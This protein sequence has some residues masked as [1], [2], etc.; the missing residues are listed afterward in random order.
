MYC[1]VWAGLFHVVSLVTNGCFYGKLAGDIY[2]PERKAKKQA[3]DKADEP[4]R[5]NPEKTKQQDET[6]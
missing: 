3:N 6:W 2:G 4:F 5:S 1:G